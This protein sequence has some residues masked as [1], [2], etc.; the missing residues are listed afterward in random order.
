[1]GSSN[2]KKGKKEKRSTAEEENKEIKK[3]EAGLHDE[4]AEIKPDEDSKEKAGNEI[5]DDGNGKGKFE[6][7]DAEEETK[8]DF[9]EPDMETI[10]EIKEQRLHREEEPE[11]EE[12]VV[13]KSEFFRKLE[14][15]WDYYKWF[16]I[17]PAI[18][19]AITVIMIVTYIEES[20]E[21]ALE[22]AIINA[23]DVPNLILEVDNDY[24]AY[25]DTVPTANDV[26]IET[27]IEYPNTNDAQEYISQSEATSMEKFNAMVIAGRVDAVVTNTW[28]ADIF[29][30]SDA[31]LD[32]REICDEEFLKERED[33]IYYAKNSEGENIP[34]AFY[35]TR[36]SFNECYD[37]D[38]PPVVVSFDTAA[39]KEEAVK[40]FEWMTE[41]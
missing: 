19:I 14:F 35:V 15:F 17:V 2:K 13:Q 21:R 16:V 11:E 36:A 31:T 29:S 37:E 12:E 22:L 4:K 32:L 7:S 38:K 9:T 39:H 26:R 28:V 24:V 34:V 30:I 20:R 23:V 25:S 1:M 40:F 33:L 10:L 5:T 27:S 6:S 18:I 3:D 41:R 8:K